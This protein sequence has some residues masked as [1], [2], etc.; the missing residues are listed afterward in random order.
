[1]ESEAHQEKGLTLDRNSERMLRVNQAFAE[2]T[3]QLQVLKLD[4]SHPGLL[5]PQEPGRSKHE[6]SSEENNIIGDLKLIRQA[7][8]QIHCPKH[9]KKY[10]MKNIQWYIFFLMENQQTIET[11]AQR[12]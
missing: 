6:S 2:T 8:L 10:G 7:S 4:L 1:M 11:D 3:A 9:N 12:L 5:V